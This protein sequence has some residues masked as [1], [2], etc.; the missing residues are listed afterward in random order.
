MNRFDNAYFITGN[1]YAGKSTMI[2]LLSEKYDGILC[3]ENYHD[4]FF[5]DLDSQKFPCLCYTRDLKDWHDFIRRTPEEYS[6]WIDGVS[7]ECEILELE[8]LKDLTK[9]GKKVF[10]DTNISVE[11]LKE[12]AIYDH[13]IIMLADPEISVK[14]F[15]ERP[16]KEKQFLYQL[17]MEEED[18]EKALANYRKGLEL[19]NSKDNYDHLL[20][21]GFKV[22][23]RDENRSIEQ[24]LKLVEEAF[25]LNS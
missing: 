4:R 8:I 3:E 9:Q 12:V 15:F 19:I 22:I 25:G 11:T 24:T 16:D 7:K 2:K 10:V 20:N 18:P 21:S 6:A 13:V 17:I 14:Q 23:L 1:A 5:S